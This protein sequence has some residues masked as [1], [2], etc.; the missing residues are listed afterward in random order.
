MSPTVP[1]ERSVLFT[2]VSPPPAAELVVDLHMSAGGGAP[3]GIR[4]R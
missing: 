1:G 2:S 3:R 4:V